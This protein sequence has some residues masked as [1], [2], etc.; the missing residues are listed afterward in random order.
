M[1]VWRGRPIVEIEIELDI[2]QMP[3]GEPWHNY[4]ASRF[5]W[6][7]ETASLTRSAMMGAHETT[8]ERLESL[9][10]LEIATPEERTTV[11]VSPG[12]PFHRRKNR[13]AH[14]RHDSRRATH[15][16]GAQKFRF[17]IAIS[18]KTTP[19]SRRSTC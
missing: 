16:V 10:Y 19:C 1:R 14:D 17:V 3:D 11:I 5:A 4:F 9:H 13:P 7:D 8:D 18:I 15:E 6:H 2:A 12:M